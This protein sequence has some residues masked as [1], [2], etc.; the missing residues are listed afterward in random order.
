ML[1]LMRKKFFLILFSTFSIF[2]FNS[3]LHAQSTSQNFPSKPVKLIVPFAAGG[4]TDVTARILGEGL[5]KIWNQPVVID[6]RAGA[7]G[8]VG[9]AVVSKADPDGYTLLLGVT[10]SHAIGP[11]LFKSLPYHPVKD[12]EP[13]IKD[14]GL[15]VLD[16]WTSTEFFRPELL[17][18]IYY[19]EIAH[20][21]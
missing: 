20:A 3:A 9:A 11:A 1:R 7:G 17:T 21:R 5:S 6:N 19:I 13:M 16:T 2:N 4:P 15:A 8:S 18:Q 14:A 10:G 12:F